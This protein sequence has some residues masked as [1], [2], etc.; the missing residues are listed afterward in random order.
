MKRQ[1]R[2]WMIMLFVL[3]ILSACSVQDIDKTPS[4]D[5]P[6]ATALPTE[7]LTETQ[8]N[9][10][11][12]TT[13]KPATEQN[14]T[15][16]SETSTT[17]VRETD[18]MPM[19]EIPAGQVWIGCD[20]TN[21]AGFSCLADE[22]PLHQV[23]LDAYF[24]DKF[25]VTNAQYA[26]CVMDGACAEP[27]YQHSATRQDYYTDP[28]YADY[29]RVA[30]SWFEAS[31]YCEWGGGRLPTEAEWVRAARTDDNRVYPWG[32][33]TPDCGKANT[34]DE[35]TGQLCLGDTAAVGSFPEGASP[36]GVMDLAGNVWEWTADWYHQDYYSNS[37]EINPQGPE[38]G[39][40][41][42]V[43]GG[44]FDY[45]WKLT[46]IAYTTDHDPREHKI[47][48]GFRCVSPVPPNDP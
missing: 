13:S 11:P 40:T 9:P 39:G 21:N 27:Y 43:H 29:P 19:I 28:D 30:V 42:V 2:F 7:I 35:N 32:N 33:E 18:N 17:Q 26:L 37:P 3:L 38:Q 41:K 34:L 5:Q 24:I 12:L 20:E 45:G 31:D 25:E 1:N 10:D 48:F 22:L 23:T 8:T 36:F 46:R 44:G 47:G 4:P 6:I 15:I 16:S 14:P